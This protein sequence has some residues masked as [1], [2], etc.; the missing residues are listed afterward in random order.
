M[1]F[2]ISLF[3]FLFVSA[4]LEMK[5]Q[6]HSIPALPGKAH[7]ISH[8]LST[9]CHS[10][11][12]KKKMRSWRK[13]IFHKREAIAMFAGP[14][15]V[16]TGVVAT[17]VKA[18]AVG[19]VARIPQPLPSAPQLSLIDGRPRKNQTVC[20]S[21]SSGSFPKGIPAS[22]YLCHLRPPQKSNSNFM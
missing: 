3:S 8:P 16:A 22:S 6:S 19:F 21:H 5:K 7:S 15:S 14:V 11:P 1:F 4:P 10:F 18:L 2:L 20:L 9:Q 17:G 13:K 12:V